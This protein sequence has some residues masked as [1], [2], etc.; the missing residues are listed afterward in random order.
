LYYYCPLLV[1]LTNNK[2]ALFFNNYTMKRIILVLFAVILAGS[3]LFAQKM[4]KVKYESQADLKIFVVQYESQAD[5]NVYMVKYESQADEDGLWYNVEYESQ[6]DFKLYF[7][8][9]ESQA[10]LKIYFCDY[11]S[12]TGWKNK[13][14]QYLLK[15]KN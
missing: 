8:E 13:S 12:Q 14:K 11:E 2:G 10:D 3:N 7:V 15:F 5:L 4:Y 6:A 1:F 9:Y